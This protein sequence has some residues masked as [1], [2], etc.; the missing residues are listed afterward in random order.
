MAGL[1]LTLTCQDDNPAPGICEVVFELSIS[2]CS[3]TPNPQQ[4][5]RPCEPV[6]ID[7]NPFET[8]GGACPPCSNGSGSFSIIITE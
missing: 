3:V 8:A 4:R 5:H 2:G 6:W 7:F 1:T